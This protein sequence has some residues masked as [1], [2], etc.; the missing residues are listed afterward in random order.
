MPDNHYAGYGNAPPDNVLIR[1]TIT[2]LRNQEMPCHAVPWGMRLPPGAVPA[3][4]AD[5]GVDS[6][7]DIKNEKNSRDSQRNAVAIKQVFASAPFP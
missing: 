4:T 2:A 7:C 1:M 3:I 5:S 6:Y